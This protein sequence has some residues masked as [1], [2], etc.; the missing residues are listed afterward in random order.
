MD[1]IYPRFGRPFHSI[2]HQLLLNVREQPPEYFRR[3]SESCRPGQSRGACGVDGILPQP[4]ELIGNLTA[5]FGLL[6]V[7]LVGDVARKLLER[8]GYARRKGLG[9]LQLGLGKPSLVD[10][11]I[12]SGALLLL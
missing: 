1:G 5:A 10:G 6:Y 11:Q 3:R 9:L 2:S 8:K 12:E 4:F 7:L